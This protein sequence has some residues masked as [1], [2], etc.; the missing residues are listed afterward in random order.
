MGH[1]TGHRSCPLKKEA[2]EEDDQEEDDQ[3]EEDQEEEEQRNLPVPVAFE[4]LEAS[5]DSAFSPIVLPS[6]IRPASPLDAAALRR[7][8]DQR[9]EQFKEQ[10]SQIELLER[11]NK[12]LKALERENQELK[13]L[14]RENQELKAQD[15]RQEASEIHQT[16]ISS[17]NEK[18]EMLEKELKKMQ[19][20][21][22]GVKAAYNAVIVAEA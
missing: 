9:E 13:A 14:E 11:E 15:T 20:E 5:A 18:I 3:E 16:T 4:P 2:Q 7:V 21:L 1:T 6:T 19:R 12:E 17:L 8:F 22:L 10:Q